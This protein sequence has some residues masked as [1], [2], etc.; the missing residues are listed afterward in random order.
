MNKKWLFLL[1]ML[2]LYAMAVNGQDCTCENEVFYQVLIVHIDDGTHYHPPLIEEYIMKDTNN[3]VSL[4][5]PTS[6]GEVRLF[7]S[8]DIYHAGSV[9]GCSPRAVLKDSCLGSA[10]EFKRLDAYMSFFYKWWK[11]LDEA[12]DNGVYEDMAPLSLRIFVSK[13]IGRTR[14]RMEDGVEYK[15]I[16]HIESIKPIRITVP[17]P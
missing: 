11:V 5:T 12:A 15:D 9:L 4:I 1:P 6:R 3:I 10:S 16:V 2:L 17:K 7:D 8:L 14:R 13:I